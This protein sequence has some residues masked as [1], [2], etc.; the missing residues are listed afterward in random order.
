MITI[1][2]CPKNETDASTALAQSNA[3]NSW[4]LL[5]DDVE[6][7]LFSPDG[8]LSGNESGRGLRHERVLVNEAG[9]PKFDDILLKG[10][11]MARWELVCYVNSDILLAPSLLDAT[12]IVD[13][14]KRP[15]L[16]LG[17]RTDLDV[18]SRIDSSIK[19]L[20]EL[21]TRAKRQG[22]LMRAGIDYFVFHRGMYA[23]VPPFAL[24][25][26]SFDNWIVWSA[27]SRDIPVVD[28]T[29]VVLAIHQNH[30]QEWQLLLESPEAIANRELAGSW[31]SSFTT[32]DATHILDAKGIKSRRV[33]A[34][35]QRGKASKDLVKSKLRGL[36]G[37]VDRRTRARTRQRTQK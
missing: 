4:Q 21:Q 9:T 29:P 24:G 17:A 11:A 15:A 25:R 8:A 28:V 14:W 5:G 1:I 34:T 22:R 23:T 2:A 26:T 7:I 36:A 16:I 30:S 12:R 20:H 27:R 10:Q 18:T 35:L 3:I 31:K 19:G 13:K 32:E 33:K 37:R 6:I